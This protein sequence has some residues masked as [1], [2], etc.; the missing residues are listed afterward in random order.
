V[1]LMGLTAELGLSQRID[2]AAH[3]RITRAME[4][5]D[6]S[7][8]AP[9]RYTD[10]SGGQ[11]QRVLLARALVS[12]PGL[13]V[14]DEPV[15]GLDL[16]TGALLVDQLTQLSHQ[17][18]LSVLVSTHSL[19]LVANHA[20]QVALFGSGR[21]T[22]GSSEEMFVADVLSDFLKAPVAVGEIAGRRVV[23]PVKPCS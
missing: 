10:L 19:D 1:V 21:V 23:V 12:D 7:D 3:S 22:S 4:R 2:G 13:L 14:L 11:R 15:R 5:F 16:A 18:G 8:L 9:R 20:D 6:V 17:D